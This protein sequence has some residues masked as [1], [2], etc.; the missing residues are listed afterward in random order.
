MLNPMRLRLGLAVAAT[1]LMA[2]AEAGSWL[3]RPP[4]LHVW[5]ASWAIPAS[6]LGATA[7]LLRRRDWAT[8][9]TVLAF[10]LLAIDNALI[11][12]GVF[13][14]AGWNS[15]YLYAVLAAA[16]ALGLQGAT[17]RGTARAA[18]WALAVAPLVLA[19]LLQLPPDGLAE[20]RRA[21]TN[22][23]WVGLPAW[24]A[25]EAWCA[26]RVQEGPAASAQSL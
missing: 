21:A 1:V 25:V 2:V 3:V 24:L 20:A 11:A 23:T 26:R 4:G 10:T 22:A 8:L 9:A 13:L 15:V 16:L 12:S 17:Q 6:A 7:A 14:F 19:V 5:W 18:A